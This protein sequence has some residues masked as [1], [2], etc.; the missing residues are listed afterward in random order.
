MEDTDVVVKD[1][2]YPTFN[3]PYNGKMNMWGCRV[4]SEC[5]NLNARCGA[6]RLC[7]LPCSREQPSASVPTI[8]NGG[9]GMLKGDSMQYL[10]VAL[11]LISG[12]FVLSITYYYC[13]FRRD[14]RGQKN[15]EKDARKKKQLSQDIMME[16]LYNDDTE[17]LFDCSP[18]EMV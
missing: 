1:G 12:L 5:C 17:I 7:S 11:A 15:K 16:N 14:A 6:D 2:C 18:T 13:Y 9:K 4:D 8:G 3:G 10:G